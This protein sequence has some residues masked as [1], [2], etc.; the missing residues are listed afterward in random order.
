MICPNCGKQLD[1]NAKFCT[2]CGAGVTPAPQAAP[3]Y[4]PPVQPAQPVYQQPYQQPAQ[5]PQYQ[6]PAPVG[7]PN[8]A[9]VGI[10]QWIGIFVLSVIPVVNLIMLIVWAAS[11]G[12]KKSLRTYAAAQLILMGV[13]VLLAIILSLAGVGLLAYLENIIG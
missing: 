10:G 13:V 12:C 8:L 4:Q 1:D 7:G 2:G 9:P 11:S 6:Q 3:A 5:Q